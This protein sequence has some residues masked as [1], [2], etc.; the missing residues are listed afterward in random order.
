MAVKIAINGFGRIGRLVFRAAMANPD[1]EVVAINDLATPE[2][3]AYLLKYD[4]VHGRYQGTVEAKDGNL[5]VDGK[6]IVVCSEKDPKNLPWAKLG[7]EVAVESTGFFT[8]AD[9][10]KAHLE[11]GA[12]KVIIS[13]PATDEDITVVL[14]VNDDKLTAAHNIISNASCTTNCLA[15]VC[16]ALANAGYN[17]KRGLMTTVHSYTNDQKML[18]QIHKDL[19]RARAGAMNIIP[20]KT[21]AAKAIGLVMP[22]LK[23]KMDGYSLRVPTCNVSVVDVVMELD[24]TVTPEELNG[25]FEKASEK[26]LK[27]I[28]GFTM[29]PVASTDF[30]NCKLSSIVD[31][32][33]TKVLDNNFVKVVSWYDN[34]TG[35]SNRVVELAAQL[36]AK[37]FV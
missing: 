29:D 6:T 37:K 12:K 8:K 2:A 20:T 10:A 14:G 36:R 23:G 15:P 28:L 30:N 32:L 22:E 19:R 7:V 18:D 11:A 33:M 5:I 16:K 17:I 4:S 31:G 9:A 1:V 35:Y 25:V 27:G 26:E 13:A 3:N 34:E 24:K 21:G